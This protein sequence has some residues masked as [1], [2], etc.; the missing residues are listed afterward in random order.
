MALA[1]EQ[2]EGL[3]ELSSGRG[4]FRGQEVNFRVWEGQALAEG[5]ILLGAV[6]ELEQ[7]REA[8]AIVGDRYR[9]PNN[10]VPYE[11]DP[12]LPN[13][14]RI[15]LAM[16]A[17]EKATP[18]RFKEHEGEADYVS[19]LRSTSSGTCNAHVGR[20]G[21]RQLVN[22][23]DGCTTGNTIHEFGHTLGLWHTQSRTD[24]N[25]HLRVLYENIDKAQWDQYN[26]QLLGG[27][28]VGPFDYGSIMLYPT[29]GF[30][31][32]TRNSMAT[33]PPGIP[34]GQRAALSA[35]DILAV[36]TLYG[37]ASQEVTLSTVPAG[38][39]LVVDGDRV[40]TP[41][42]FAWAAGEVHRI[43]A[44][45]RHAGTNANSRLE[46]AK[47][48]DGGER[49]HEVVAAPG[50][51]VIA[52][53]AEWVLLRT[54]VSPAGSG[55][56]EVSPPSED[57]FY[58]LGTTV[59]IRSAAEGD[60][61]FYR[62]TAGVGGATYL[63]ANRMGNASN[64]VELT[65][66]A[67]NAFYQA[68][69]TRSAVTTIAST[70]PGAQL[71]VDGATLFAPSA[72]AWEAGTRHSVSVLERTLQP[73]SVSRLVFQE[74]SNGG[75]RTQDIV[76]GAGGVLTA[77]AAQQHQVIPRVAST[78]LT[79]TSSPNTA[80][81]IGLEPV[82]A[83]GF[84]DEGAE[85]AV[86]AEGPEGVPFAH[87]YGDL[88]GEANPQLLRI[89]EQTVVG[90]NFVSPGLFSSLAVVND[91]GR[92]PGP[93]ASNGVFTIFGN[94]IG[95]SA[96]DATGYAVLVGGQRAELLQL[97]RNAIRF[98]APRLAEG[99]TVT[100]ELQ[101]PAGVAR[102]TLGVQPAAPGI[103]TVSRAGTG[104]VDARNGDGS[105]NRK[106][107]PAARG[108]TLGLRVTG[109]ANPAGLEVTL[110]GVPAE[111]LELRE[112]AAGEYELALRLP[113]SCPAG[114]EVPVV[115]WSEG[116]RSQFGTWAAV[117]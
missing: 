116:V 101:T 20:I 38:L 64:P 75:E 50:L 8:V 117:R 62:W 100:V 79:G 53:Y 112:G 78:R 86:A 10:I 42:T 73:G 77:R 34:I 91:A 85:L 33:I 103:Y 32:N 2:T 61:R 114:P 92:Q 9:W 90:A 7:G 19:I 25:R 35:Q 87:W 15:R 11:L 71:S 63:N 115:V 36:R 89:T 54:G 49:A 31:R 59:Q 65:I 58:P 17:W 51:H 27:Q 113:E 88:G 93:L 6:K 26:Q 41:R 13:Q 97:E 66:R 105:L 104:Q 69:F 37:E 28:D 98:R 47:W 94:G 24:R 29:T 1:Q 43:E 81:N 99:S 48:S 84:Y 55:R 44:M 111:I 22:L 68:S 108:S 14:D 40:E 110:G 18:L 39:P 76:A 45:P 74:W 67:S 56:V 21:G 3:R 80:R 46:F 30:T 102:R 83:D 57:G 107:A 5:D 109:I 52:N 4:F 95:P 106:E 72:F 96:G 16:E 70:P 60:F 82:S 23:G 12:N